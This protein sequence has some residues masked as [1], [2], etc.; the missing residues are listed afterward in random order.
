MKSSRKHN[1]ILLIFAVIIISAAIV[2]FLVSR[3]SKEFISSTR[4]TIEMGTAASVTLHDRKGFNFESSTKKRQD[5]IIENIF[6]RIDDLDNSILSWRSE[7]SETYAFNHSSGT[8]PFPCSESFSHA[9]LESLKL[10]ENSEGA[11]DITLRLVIDA[12]G[13]EA[14][15]GSVPYF[16]PDEKT[17]TELK[18]SIGSEHLS[19]DEQLVQK[20]DVAVQIDF[21]AVGK[22]YALDIVLNELIKSP[23]DGAVVSVG[24]SILVYGDKGEPWQIGIRDPEGTPADFLGRLSIPGIKSGRAFISTSGGYEKFVEYEG[25]ILEH[26]ID[27]RT[28]HPVQSRLFSATIITFDNGLVSDGLSTACYI[29]GMENSKKLLK[30]YNAEAIFITKTKEV[31]IT[32]GLSG[33]FTITDPNYKFAEVLY[34]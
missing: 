31:Y 12:W 33:M 14:Y 8:E 24:G 27:G 34:R 13:I 5:Q 26:I 6:S 4:T 23:V 2:F 3:E 19:A 32:E 18:Q 30:Q 7:A 22:G 11:L 10:A 29:L 28:L 15:D 1:R 17:I 16:P 9:V 20:D 25:E 21:G